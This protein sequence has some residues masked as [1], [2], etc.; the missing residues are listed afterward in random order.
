MADILTVRQWLIALGR[1]TVARMASDEVADYLNELSPMLADRFP[2]AMFTKASLEHVAAESAYL[3]VY[4]EIVAR[5]R[6]FK[7]ANPQTTQYPRLSDAAGDLN[8]DERSWV[9]YYRR[10]ER[11]QWR[12]LREPDGRLS[13]PD[14]TDWREHT[15]SLIRQRAPNAWRYLSDVPNP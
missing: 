2:D 12:P 4:G 14:V 1:L 10:R 6:D 8:P 5:L 7:A 11:E 3:P 15:A 9:D 13:R